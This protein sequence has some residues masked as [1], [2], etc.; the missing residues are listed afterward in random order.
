MF[1]PMQLFYQRKRL[2]SP[3]I[4]SL[5]MY[6]MY[7]T[8]MP[9][10]RWK[11]IQRITI[12]NHD[13]YPQ[14]VHFLDLVGCIW[15]CCVLHT[16]SV[17]KTERMKIIL[18]LWMWACIRRPWVLERCLFGRSVEAHLHLL[19]LPRPLCPSKCNEDE[20]R[21]THPRNVL[22]QLSRQLLPTVRLQVSLCCFYQ[23]TQISNQATQWYAP[24]SC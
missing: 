1:Y 24:P 15:Y 2:H 11:K 21:G 4:F 8:S 20:V 7:K 22:H 14:K 23:P 3:F 17:A 6:L 16:A 9:N 5:N 18:L 13:I 10:S 19:A 12:R